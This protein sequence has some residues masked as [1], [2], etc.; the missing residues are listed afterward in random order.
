MQKILNYTEGTVNSI[1]KSKKPR[2][3]ILSGASG[4]TDVQLINLIDA[5]NDPKNAR[6]DYINVVM[7]TEKIAEG[8]TLKGIVKFFSFRADHRLKYIS[9]AEKRGYRLGSHDQLDPSE[10]VYEI[11]R[12]DSCL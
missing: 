8:I 11:N 4:D 1:S 2:F 3:I 6:G 10:R 12:L 7:G 5:F 9:Q